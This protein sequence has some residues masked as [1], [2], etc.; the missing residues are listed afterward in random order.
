MIGIEGVFIPPPTGICIRD[1]AGKFGVDFFIVYFLNDCCPNPGC[2]P[3]NPP[4]P[5]I[6][7]DSLFF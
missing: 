1:D 7:L 4:S 6:F 5:L 3:A 2:N